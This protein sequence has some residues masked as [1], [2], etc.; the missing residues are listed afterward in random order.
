M[1][2]APLDFAVI[3]AYFC[4]TGR[5]RFSL[6]A[7]AATAADGI[8]PRWRIPIG[9]RQKA[10]ATLLS[11]ITYLSIP[12]EMIR[13]GI[14][15][16]RVLA[17][18]PVRSNRESRDHAGHPAPADPFLAYQYLEKRAAGREGAGPVVFVTHTMIWSG[19]IFTASLAVSCGRLEPGAH[20]HRKGSH[21]S[22]HHRRRDP[23]GDLTD[24]MQLLIPFEARWQS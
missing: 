14:T 9:G 5:D 11:T 18:I 8:G 3:V 17:M 24:N 20:H 21:D 19:I 10:L 15:F 4:G 16:F 7:D 22:K 23:D 1:H 2:L 12:G 13:Y 6:L